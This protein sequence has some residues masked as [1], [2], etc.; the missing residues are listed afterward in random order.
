MGRTAQEKLDE[1]DALHK[2]AQRI[3][4]HDSAS[5]AQLERL[6]HAKRGSAIKQLR[7]RPGK[8]IK[9]AVESGKELDV[10]T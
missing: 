2:T 1:A 7:R 8:R 6:A 10:G 4:S 5:A 9:G 3:K